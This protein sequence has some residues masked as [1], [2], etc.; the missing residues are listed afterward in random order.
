[1]FSLTT[2]HPYDAATT[3]SPFDEPRT[4][5][6]PEDTSKGPVQKAHLVMDVGVLS[7]LVRYLLSWANLKTYQGAQDRAS[8]DRCL[9]LF[10]FD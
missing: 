3:I 6:A 5:H 1:M 4:D 7:Q 9:V 10:H 8:T 2:P